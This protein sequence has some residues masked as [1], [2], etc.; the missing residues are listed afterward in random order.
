MSMDFKVKNEEKETT[1][2][3]VEDLDE[4]EEEYDEV[5]E[6]ETTSSS[7]DSGNSEKKKLVRLLGL[8]LGVIIVFILVLFLLTSCTNGSKSYEEVEEIMV[9]A[10]ESYF[11]DHQESLPKKD[12]GSQTIDASVLSAEGY[13]KDL[14]KYT[15]AICTGTVFND[16]SRAI[17]I[18]TGP[19]YFSS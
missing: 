4:I 13:M 2:E 14:S 16:F 18:E 5:E 9:N 12:G 11:A 3:V 17:A 19:I 10:A 6:L 7:S 1:E 15:K 8:L